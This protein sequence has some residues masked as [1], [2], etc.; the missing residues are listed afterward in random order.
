MS[1]FDAF[2]P[3]MRTPSVA[4]GILHAGIVVVALVG[5]PFFTRP[6]PPEPEPMIVDF[7]EIGSKAASPVVGPTPPVSRA[8]IAKEATP[9]PPPTTVEKPQPPKPE[10]P[11]QPEKAEVVPP[12]KAQ[13]QPTPTVQKAPDPE[14][15]KPDPEVALQK[16]KEPEPPKPEPPKPAPPQ[17]PQVKKPDPKPEPPKPVQTA[18]TVTPPPKPQPKSADDIINSLVNKNPTPQPH[19]P[20][21]ESPK[22]AQ[23]TRTATAA[24]NQAQRL[25][26][27]EM[28]AMA[29]RVRPCWNINSSAMDAQQL[30][31]EI[32]V[33]MR[34]DGSVSG[35][36]V[37]T[38]IAIRGA[39]HQAFAQAALRAVLNPRCQPLPYPQG[40][41]DSLRQFI[42]RFDPRDL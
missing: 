14:P 31:V 30:V 39:A 40:K 16:P 29:D 2:S 41:Y 1:I 28:A 3:E 22:P 17:T 35:A 7:E 38:G 20:V 6:E 23:P 32:I 42:F 15:P 19:K 4:S 8:P 34:E 5:L 33:D 18:K 21:Q 13:Q 37:G 25:T 24:P 12:P 11:K 9:A 36:Q 10:P 27:S 26:V